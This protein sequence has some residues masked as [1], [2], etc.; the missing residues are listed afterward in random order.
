VPVKLSIVDLAAVPPGGTAVDAFANSVALAQ[1]AERL[2]F[3]RYWV[4]EHHGV[5]PAVASASPEILATR[6]AAATTRIRVGS[7][8]VLLNYTRPL[9]VAETFRSLHAMFPGRIDLGMGRATS[10]AVVEAALRPQA[11]SSSARTDLEADDLADMPGAAP[12][13]LEALEAWMTYEQD[14]TDVVDWLAGAFPAGDSR[15]AIRLSP[16]VAGGPE[17]WLL[18]SSP[19]SALL[20]GRL[21]LR[22][23]FAAFFNPALAAA[24]LRAYQASF[25]PSSA[26]GGVSEPCCMLAVNVCC[27]DSDREAARLRASAELFYQGG[28]GADRRPLV[29]ADTAVAELGG[30]PQ[31]AASADPWVRHICG[32]PTSVRVHLERLCA[33]VG[34]D[35]LMVQDLI[36]DPGERTRSYELLAEAFGLAP[37]PAP[38]PDGAVGAAAA[39]GAGGAVSLP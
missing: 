36:A 6:I 14:V 23:G 34:T 4:A 30:L 38:P 32:G 16:G 27:A 8:T 20:A 25:Q 13:M 15:A 37:S 9:R 29:D 1:V 22:Y 5:G 10:P 2:G 28:A 31:L 35:E 24:S 39:V 18:G 21:G 7:G 26:P 17:P 3:H 33:E 12:G 19:T 11:E